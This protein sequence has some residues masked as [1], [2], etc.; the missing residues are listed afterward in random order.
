[1]S[2]G[3]IIELV[4]ERDRA[5]AELLEQYEVTRDY[6]VINKR[7]NKRADT[8]TS[9]EPETASQIRRITHPFG[10]AL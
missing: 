3:R 8:H 9:V 4:Q 10:F 5:R 6:L 2:A 7:W 1:M